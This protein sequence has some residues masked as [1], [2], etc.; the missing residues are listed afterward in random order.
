METI[1]ESCRELKQVLGHV[2]HGCQ[3]ILTNLNEFEQYLATYAAG[4]LRRKLDILGSWINAL[5]ELR[6]KEHENQGYVCVFLSEANGFNVH[7]VKEEEIVADKA[8]YERTGSKV[9]SVEE[10]TGIIID[11]MNN[12]TSGN[13]AEVLDW[14]KKYAKSPGL[15]FSKYSEV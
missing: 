5:A 8:Y 10:A 11:M 13:W 2:E 4:C 7:W 6:Y 14:V 1:E 15:D 3:I 12:L 9:L